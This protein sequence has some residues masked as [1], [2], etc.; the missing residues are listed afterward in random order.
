MLAHMLAMENPLVQAEMVEAME[1]PTLADRHQ[2]S[3]VPHTVIN[4]GAGNV[5]GAVPESNLVAAIRDALQK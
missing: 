1:F 4:D 5:V 3:G 2:V